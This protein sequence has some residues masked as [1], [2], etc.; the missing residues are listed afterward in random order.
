GPPGPKS[1]ATSTGGVVYTRWGR[2]HCPNTAKTVKIYSATGKDTFVY[3]VILKIGAIV[4]AHYTHG[5]SGSN[6][7]CLPLNPINEKY[8]A[9][10]QSKAIIYGT[11]GS[12]MMIPSRI[13]C[14]SEWTMEYK[15]YLMAAHYSHKRYE[16]ICVEGK[17]EAMHGSH[18][19]KN[20]ALLYFVEGH[21]GSL[22]CPPYFHGKELTCVVCT[23]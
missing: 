1:K 14:P 13:I 22:P 2:K 4:E 16:Y 21:C 20:G 23:Q 3:C 19:D 18:E 5:G 10:T 6:Y 9:G 12:H 17:P 15:G 7:L 11:G 8:A